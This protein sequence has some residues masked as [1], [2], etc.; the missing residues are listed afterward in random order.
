M[1]TALVDGDVLHH[2]SLWG[3]SN[4]KAYQDNVLYNVQEWC[5]TCVATEVV[6]AVGGP[7]NFR[8]TLYP[9]YKATASRSAARKVRPNHE[10]EC[11]DWLKSHKK[12]VVTNGI[13]ADDLLTIMASDN[14]VIVT[15]DKDLLQID[16][17]HYNPRLGLSGNRYVNPQEAFHNFKRQLLAGDPMDKI[18]G[19]PGVGPKK[20]EAALEAGVDP[21]DAY[22]TYYGSNWKEPFEFNGK[23]LFLLRTYDDAFSVKRYEELKEDAIKRTLEVCV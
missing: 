5:D 11:L 2:W 14:H 16:G 20:A 1:K 17:H 23:L 19:V 15:V 7:N 12:A 4:L 22:K 13:E 3:T 10:K 21:I 18:P 6:I 8:K 9:G